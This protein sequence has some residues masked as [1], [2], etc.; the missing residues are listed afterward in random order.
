MF[1][2]RVHPKHDVADL[3]LNQRIALYDAILNTV[4]EVIAQGGRYDET[5]L[6]SQPGQYV[7][8]MDKNTVDHPCPECGRSIQKMSYL[9]GTC[10]FCTHCQK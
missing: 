10:Y 4:H 6:Y 9:G 8:L 2:G 5:D 3:T 1:R 7:R